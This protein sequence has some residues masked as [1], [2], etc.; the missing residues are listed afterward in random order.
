[1]RSGLGI[2]YDADADLVGG[3]R[4]AGAAGER[5]AGEDEHER[6]EGKPMAA[7]NDVH[8]SG[9]SAEGTGFV[10]HKEVW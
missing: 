8:V 10:A 4:G 5:R 6:A 7:E 2:D 3:R 1:M 9:R